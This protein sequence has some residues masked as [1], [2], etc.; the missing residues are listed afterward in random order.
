MTGD[1]PTERP[2]PRPEG[3][4]AWEEA[5]RLLAFKEGGS[6]KAPPEDRPLASRYLWSAGVLVDITCRGCGSRGCNRCAGTG[7][8]A[9]AFQNSGG[10]W[11]SGSADR[12]LPAV[13]RRLMTALGLPGG[14]VR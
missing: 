8:I 13:L 10:D 12:R 1:A 6:T 14:G 4:L 11:P 7:A 5:Q 2:D 3:Y 9:E